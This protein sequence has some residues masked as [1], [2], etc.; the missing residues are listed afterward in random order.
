MSNPTSRSSYTQFAFHVDMSA[1]GEQVRDCFSSP[2]GTLILALLTATVTLENPLLALSQTPP[3]PTQTER[4]H[5]SI[6]H[7]DQDSAILLIMNEETE[8]ISRGGLRDEQ[9]ISE[10]PANVYV[11][12]EEDIRHSGATDIPTILRRIPG[13]EVMQMSGADYNVS[14]RGDNQA[15]ANKLLVLID[16]R[17][18][19]EYAFGSVLWTLLPVTLPE[20]N[21]IE[22]MKGPSAAIY[23]FNAFDGVVNIITK[24]P[25]Q[26]KG[27]TNGTFAQI[28]AG[29][30]GTIRSTVIQAGIH[31]DFGYRLSFAHDQ[32]Q[33][34]N[35]RDALALRSNKFNLQTEYALRDSSK[36]IVSGGLVDSNRFDGQ[37]FDVVRES[38]KITNGYVNA[39]YERPN[40]FI[41]TSWT[42]WDESRLELLNPAIINTFAAITDRNGNNNQTFIHD[43]YTTWIQHALDLTPTNRF[44]YGANYFHN[45]TSDVNV[46]D[47]ESASEDRLGFYLQDE[48]RATK[49]LTFVAGLRWDMHS[50]VNSTYSPRLAVI[51]KPHEDHTFRISGSVAYRPPNLLE[52]RNDTRQVIIPFAFS[53]TLLGSRNL[54]PEKIVSYEAGYQGWYWKHRIRV[55]ADAF[56]NHLSNFIGSASTADPLVFT[57]GN[58]GQAD[59]YGAEVG[60]EFLATSWLTGFIN[61]STVQIHQTGDLIAQQGLLTRGA[62]SYKINAGLRGEW[63]SGWS[64]ETLVH[65]VSAASYPI[66]PGY[67]FFADTFGGFTPPVNAVGGYTLLN[68]RGAYR[69]WHDKA[70]VAVSVF[71]AL[72]DHHRENPVGE[73]IGSRVMGWLTLRY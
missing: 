16:G 34:W 48:W 55:R 40:F 32:N 36:I 69:F 4:R 60:A 19:Y 3:G 73:E 63:D 24:S 22:V 26:M 44:T 5:P 50:E 47:S 72:N 67:A 17:P 56:F 54:H 31:G 30:F 1:R 49:T 70:E 64:A 21:K 20:I 28:G 10:A 68:L 8:S 2:A 45:A 71:N 37:V 61:Y 18:I 62:P 6:G 12:T 57:F 46:F 11:I 52:T 65:H 43:V 15:A 23:G 13:M 51:Y 58:L 14:V 53:T 35:N 41:R 7:G 33:Q 42:R 66:S 38:S 27:S 9:R 25:R 59:I 39:A 29:E